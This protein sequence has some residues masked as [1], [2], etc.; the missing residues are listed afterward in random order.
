MKLQSYFAATVEAAMNMA[1]LEMGSDAMLISSR[2][3]DE[4]SCHLGDYEVVFASTPSNDPRSLVA[5]SPSHAAAQIP[6]VRT[7]VSKPIDKLSYE[8][9]GLKREMQRLAS[10]LARST[11]SVAKI[12]ANA[13]LAE[14]FSRLLNS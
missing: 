10:A 3:T 9:A 11:A 2:R 4:Q 8:A 1:R 12:S 13:Q 6:P 14:A 5:G 7:P